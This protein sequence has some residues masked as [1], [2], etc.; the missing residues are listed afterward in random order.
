MRIT[1]LGTGT[2]HGI[3][4]LGCS[5][6]VCTSE[7]V[8]NVRYRSSI[9]VESDGVSVVV[10]TGYEFRLSGIRAG[11]RK[12][13]AV[14]YTHSHSDHIMGLDDLRVFTR[15]R[16]LPVFGNARTIADIK[17]KFPYA[18][19]HYDGNYGLPL[20]D[21]CVL[22]NYRTFSVGSLEVLPVPVSHGCMEILG[23]RFSNFAYVTDVS[24]I[25]DES[26]EALKGVDVLVLGALRKRPHATHFSFDQ[27]MEAFLRIG[28]GCCYFTHVNHETSYEE[29]NRLYGR[30]GIQSAYDNLVLEV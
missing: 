30:F 8:R 5:C 20:L 18:F 23:Y 7:D 12:V 13:D 24:C 26:Y 10:D 9:L 2:S 27:A 17:E 19:R 22:E 3:P 14:L 15:D 1:F 29:I 25:G 28:A 6:P 4:V 11:L 16:R 21:A